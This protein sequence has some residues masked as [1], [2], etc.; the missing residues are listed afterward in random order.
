MSLHP[1]PVPFHFLPKSQ[2]LAI[3]GVKKSTLYAWIKCGRFPA[4]VYL[5]ETKP[6]WL[7]NEVS[8]WMNRQVATREAIHPLA[9]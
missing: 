8:D 1:S 2:V 9:A 3:I 5:S 6:V 4:P 7:S